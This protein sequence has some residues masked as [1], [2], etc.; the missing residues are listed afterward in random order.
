MKRIAAISIQKAFKAPETQKQTYTDDELARLL[1]KP[2]MKTCM[3]ATYRTWVII[4]LLMDC[5]CRIGTIRE[6]KMRMWIL[7][8]PCITSPIPKTK[9][10]FPFHFL[11]KWGVSSKNIWNCTAVKNRTMF[12]PLAKMNQP[13]EKISM[14]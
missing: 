8:I 11:H 1:K 5:G 13:K 7:I 12:S 9:R 6:L 3:F 4:N 10:R 14:G 2:D